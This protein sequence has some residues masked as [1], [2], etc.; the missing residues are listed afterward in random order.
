[1][2]NKEC[3][4]YKEL[5]MEKIDGEISDNDKIQL[6]IHIK[7]CE[8][9]NIYLRKMERI[10][11]AT[12]SL[13]YDIP[14]FLE[15]KIMS[16]IAEKEYKQP[17]FVF[18]FRRVFAYAVSF[19][20]ILFISVF[21]IYNKFD[22]KTVQLSDIS[23]T[24]EVKISKQAKNT[25]LK[26]KIEKS[27]EIK[28]E[29]AMNENIGTSITETLPAEP[30]IAINST[31]IEEKTQ[32][33]P[34]QD[35]NIKKIDT[36]KPG[37]EAAKVTPIPPVPYNPLLLQDKAIVANN[38]INPLRGDVATIRFIVDD[39]VFVKIAIYDKNIRPVSII[40]NE[41]KGR[42]TYEAT[43]SGKGDN[44]EIVSE[45][46]YFVYIQIGSRVIKKSIIVNK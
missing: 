42:G 41:E 45:G 28:S 6:E 29:V 33:K 17:V 11:K 44:N 32:I 34:R 40:L 13:I 26:S 20:V 12:D 36:I 46:V 14:P 5:I 19:S 15:E 24:K 37:L 7:S 1:M 30:K 21:L 16:K 39:T 38:V 35:Y 22:N 18:D 31:N 23:V 9:C 25:E 2:G 3:K 43:W 10:K 27:I 4:K 8:D